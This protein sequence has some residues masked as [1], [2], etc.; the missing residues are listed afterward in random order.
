MIDLA[1]VVQCASGTATLM[2]GLL[3]KPMV[4]MY[5]MN[6]L[7][8]FLAKR[9]V[10]STKYFGLI[11]LVLDQLAVREV[12]QEEADTPHLVKELETADR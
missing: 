4:I 7:T 3:E 6:R 1:D 9:F 2:V 11:N 5:R 8:A 10:K 12:F